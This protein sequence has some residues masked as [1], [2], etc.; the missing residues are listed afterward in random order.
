MQFKSSDFD[1]FAGGAGRDYHLV[2]FLNAGYLQTNSQ[3]NLPGL[4]NQF[5]LMAKASSGHKQ[6][7]QLPTS[8]SCSST[9]NSSRPPCSRTPHPKHPSQHPSSFRVVSLLPPVQAFKQ[10]P[11]ADNIFFAELTYENSKELY[12]R[13]NVKALPFIFHWGPESSAKEGRSIKLSKSSQVRT[14]GVAAAAARC[15]YQLHTAQGLSVVAAAV[16]YM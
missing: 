7:P 2:F 5:A 15:R 3:M 1:R 13:L 16:R 11:D 6:P 10:G 9:V 14:W 12:K 4:R 8:W